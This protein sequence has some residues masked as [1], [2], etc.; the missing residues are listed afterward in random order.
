ML[1]HTIQNIIKM[2]KQRVIGCFQL[3][4]R[5]LEM[6]NEYM[7]A[8]QSHTGYWASEDVALLLLRQIYEK[9][10]NIFISE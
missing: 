1:P 5:P 10:P 6:F 8:F 7:F 4:E 2:P 9:D 3:Q